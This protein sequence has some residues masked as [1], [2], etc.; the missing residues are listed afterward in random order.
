MQR[1]RRLHVLLGLFFAPAIVCFALSGVF[2]VL[3]FH[4][5]RG[6]MEAPA[7]IAKLAEIHRKQ[8]V[9]PLVKSAP[10]APADKTEK[11]AGEI[12][13]S[14]PFRVFVVALGTG[15]VVTT[16]LGVWMAYKS[17][18]DRKLVWKMLALGLVIPIVLLCF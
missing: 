11:A 2:M 5:A 15:L 9:S 6:E 3:G 1:V 7:W 16:L 12:V 18:R 14:I 10:K 13:P 4:K 8:S 17:P